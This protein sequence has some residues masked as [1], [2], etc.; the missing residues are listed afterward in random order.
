MQKEKQ[1]K[2]VKVLVN[3]YATSL[4]LHIRRQSST[5]SKETAVEVLRICVEVLTT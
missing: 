5:I 2:E 3:G 4:P 1:Q